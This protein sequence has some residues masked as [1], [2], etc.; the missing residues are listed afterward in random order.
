MEGSRREGLL[1]CSPWYKALRGAELSVVPGSLWSKAFRRAKLSGR[2][3]SIA[4][5]SPQHKARCGATLSMVGSCSAARGPC[6]NRTKM[7]L[8]M[9]FFLQSALGAGWVPGGSSWSLCSGAS[10]LHSCPPGLSAEQ[11]PG[12]DGDTWLGSRASQ[13]LIMTGV[14]N[15]Q[16]RWTSLVTLVRHSHPMQTLQANCCRAGGQSE[17]PRLTQGHLG[18]HPSPSPLP[19]SHTILLLFLALLRAVAEEQGNPALQLLP[20]AAGMQEGE[21]A[22]PPAE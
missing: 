7:L 21:G 6:T 16:S 22:E 3:F 4:Q 2:E 12:E 20:G 10:L 8:G 13:N 15:L 19:A 17:A 1:Q 9:L 14:L 5:S 11:L 18:H